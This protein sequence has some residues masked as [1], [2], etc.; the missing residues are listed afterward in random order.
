MV[1]LFATKEVETEEEF[2]VDVVIPQ[3]KDDDDDDDD[4]D[5]DLDADED[6]DELEELGDLDDWSKVKDDNEDGGW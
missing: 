2:L 1:L 3:A 5:W 6:V 4:D